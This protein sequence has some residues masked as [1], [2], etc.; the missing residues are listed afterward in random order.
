MFN[1]KN[2]LQAAYDRDMKYGT[3]IQL[4]N[5]KRVSE[6]RDRMA[7]FATRQMAE[8]AETDRLLA[9]LA[10]EERMAEKQLEMQRER[11]MA[12]GKLTQ[13][14]GVGPNGFFT[15]YRPR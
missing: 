5:A 9:K 6:G 14:R 11:L 4:Q 8:Q 10:A 3:A 12:D 15:G 2:L 1:N 7:A 13:V